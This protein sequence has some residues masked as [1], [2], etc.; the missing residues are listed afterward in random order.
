MEKFTCGIKK[1]FWKSNRP[2]KCY[3]NTC[4]N[5]ILHVI[6]WHT[7]IVIGWKNIL[8]FIK[9]VLYIKQNFPKGHVE[10]LGDGK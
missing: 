10:Y 4:F 7:F 9:A 1:K 3:E 2:F 6:L 8:Y 5:K